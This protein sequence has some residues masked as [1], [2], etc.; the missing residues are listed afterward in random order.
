MLISE[1]V[2][3]S[4]NNHSGLQV[5]HIILEES[6]VKNV[7]PSSKTDQLGKG[8]WLRLL[9]CPRSPIFLGIRMSTYLAI[10][11][12]I[13]GVLFV[14]VDCSPLT[15][16]Q[17]NRVLSECCKALHLVKARISSPSLR[18]VLPRKW[19]ILVLTRIKSLCTWKSNLF[20]SYVPPN[21]IIRL[22]IGGTRVVWIIGHS[23]M[24][25][26]QQHAASHYC[27]TNLGLDL[28]SFKYLRTGRI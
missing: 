23:F 7:I 17:F 21:L 28:D 9:S 2:S 26:A 16:F 6:E 4:K 11:P 10:R 25:W 12:K 8:T 24:Y 19:L 15:K 20:T 13:G 18:S 3:V 27:S 1:S 14:H 22:A 5:Q